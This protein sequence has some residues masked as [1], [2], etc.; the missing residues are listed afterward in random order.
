MPADLSRNA[1]GASRSV[2][3]GL[4]RGLEQGKVVP[5]QRLV[6]TDLAAQHGVGRNA[7]REAIQWLAAQCM[8]DVSRFRSPAIRRLEEGEAQEVLDAA[9]PIL[10]LMARAAARN[11]RAADHAAQL[12]AARTELQSEDFPRARRHFYG[13][14]LAIG[15]NRELLRL[16]RVSGLQILYAQYREAGTAG[17]AR[18]DLEALAEAVSKGHAEA[19]EAAA[20]RHVEAIRKAVTP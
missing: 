7:V 10:V 16:F 20:K 15:G 8:I 1:K 11:F 3:R 12:A 5:G 17:L 13:T 4:M 19:A 14:L 2:S 18:P 6:E 9:E